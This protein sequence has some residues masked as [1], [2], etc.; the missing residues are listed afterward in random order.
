MSIMQLELWKSTQG[1]VTGNS[2]KIYTSLSVLCLLKRKASDMLPIHVILFCSEKQCT[3]CTCG[4]HCMAKMKSI[5]GP[6]EKKF[7]LKRGHSAFAWRA[8]MEGNPLI[9]FWDSS[10]PSFL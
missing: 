6:P 7:P 4:C 10:F 2:C 9:I 8:L 5:I 1:P 3:K